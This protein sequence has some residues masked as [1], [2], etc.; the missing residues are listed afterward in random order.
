MGA[1]VVPVDRDHPRNR[2]PSDG[3]ER[4]RRRRGNIP[5][6]ASQPPSTVPQVDEHASIREHLARILASRTF[7]Q[8]DR[9]KRFLSFIVSEA[10]TGHRN[11]LKEYVIGVQ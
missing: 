6:M 10:I 9:L 8:V 1:A 2:L 11:E 7:H 4:R 5:Q 3:V